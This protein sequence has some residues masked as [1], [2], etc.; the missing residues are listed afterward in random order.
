MTPSL[1]LARRDDLLSHLM[2]TNA[3]KLSSQLKLGFE[4]AQY[5]HL[6]TPELVKA[7]QDIVRAELKSLAVEKELVDEKDLDVYLATACS[8]FV[9]RKMHPL[10]PVLLSLI[11]LRHPILTLTRFSVERVWRSII[12][13]SDQLLKTL[14]ASPTPGMSIEAE[15]KARV[16][17]VFDRCPIGKRIGS[18]S[19]SRTRYAL[20][21]L[22]GNDLHLSSSSVN[23]RSILDVDIGPPPQ[24]FL[25]Q[26]PD[27]PHGCM[28]QPAIEE[29]PLPSAEGL[30][31][32][33]YERDNIFVII[34]A[35]RPSIGP[36]PSIPPPTTPRPSSTRVDDARRGLFLPLTPRSGGVSSLSSAAEVALVDPVSPVS[37]L[38]F[39]AVV[40]VLVH[41]AFS[42]RVMRTIL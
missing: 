8:H 9:L 7:G 39:I 4:L 25:P 19:S 2:E 12:K 27:A 11:A 22:S 24:E 3:S 40:Q 17:E 42:F 15:G 13:G 33:L 41:T 6:I 30:P 29:I 16:V 20:D 34:E 28:S 36:P 18:G 32:A 35:D 1:Q 31:P 38:I 23:K 10:Y 5:K 14:N 21:V 26:L 37:C